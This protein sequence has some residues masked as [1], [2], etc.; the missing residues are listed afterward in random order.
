[1]IEPGEASLPG[2]D[3]EAED[4]V[5]TVGK[6]ECGRKWMMR[7]PRIGREESREVW[8]W[9][10]MPGTVPRQELGAKARFVYF[11]AGHGPEAGMCL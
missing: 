4:G 10:D 2:C 3:S 8:T 7:L 5:E 6:V 1:V 11:L 9:E